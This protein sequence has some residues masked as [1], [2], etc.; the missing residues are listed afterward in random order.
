[1]E[2]MSCHKD[3]LTK[4]GA[5]AGKP[6]TDTESSNCRNLYYFGDKGN[7]TVAINQCREMEN[8][9]LLANIKPK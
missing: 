7:Q 9:F 8:P 2:V 3:N 1:M 6:V 5:L 4:L